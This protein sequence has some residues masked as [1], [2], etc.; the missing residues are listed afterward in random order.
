MFKY[1]FTERVFLNNLW[2]AC[3]KKNN[4]NKKNIYIYTPVFKNVAIY[5]IYIY[6][7]CFLIRKVRHETCVFHAEG[8][9]RFSFN[10]TNIQKINEKN[11]TSYLREMEQYLIDSTG[12]S[13]IL[14]LLKV[15]YGN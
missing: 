4:D 11:P 13:S 10:K 3:E 5:M 6:A 9:M 15:H 1:K 2:D 7:F 8:T 12:S 14:I